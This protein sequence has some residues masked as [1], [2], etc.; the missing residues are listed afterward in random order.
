[1]TVT[2]FTTNELDPKQASTQVH[3]WIPAAILGWRHPRRVAYIHRHP[4]LQ[5]QCLYFWNHQENIPEPTTAQDLL[6]LLEDIYVEMR[7]EFKA[8]KLV[9]DADLGLDGRIRLI[10]GFNTTCATT[11]LSSLCALSPGR[12]C[13]PLALR[14]RPG[15]SHGVVLPALFVDNEWVDGRP[16]ARDDK[17][18]ALP[19][20]DLLTEVQTLLRHAVGVEM[21][22]HQMRQA[23]KQHA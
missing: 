15:S 8:H 6:F 19:P 9:I 5:D 23:R 1:M 7:G 17:G 18:N 16:M 11:L 10:C 21:L 12:L 22:P 2:H 4:Q 14:V 20:T 3:N 13:S